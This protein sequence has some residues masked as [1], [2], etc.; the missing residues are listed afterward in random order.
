MNCMTAAINLCHFLC[1]HVFIL[2]QVVWKKEPFR[3]F[4]GANVSQAVVQTVPT[5]AIKQTAS[6]DEAKPRALCFSVSPSEHNPCWNYNF[7]RQKVSPLRWACCIPRYLAGARLAEH[8]L[9]KY[10]HTQEKFKNLYKI[11]YGSRWLVLS[12]LQK[13]KY[14][15]S[16]IDKYFPLKSGSQVI[17][18]ITCG[19][20][21]H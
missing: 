16:L 7:G 13:L 6:G 4:S 5:F 12:K 9:P 2:N 17:S 15:N 8:S 11:K 18:Q 10:E 3:L 21:L 19:Q 14:I 20:I 1:V